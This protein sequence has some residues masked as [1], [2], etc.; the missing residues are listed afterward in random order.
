MRDELQALPK[1]KN[2]SMIIN[3]NKSNEPGSHWIG[4]FIS[5]PNAYYFD[6]YGMPPLPE[7]KQYLDKFIPNRYRNTLQCQNYNDTI[8][9]N[10]A[11]SVL[12]L[13]QAGYDYHD[14]CLKLSKI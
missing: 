8:C 10:L 14:I 7:V 13:L 6:S 2:C 5:F 4:L 3:F 9:G 12:W 1:Y 11:L